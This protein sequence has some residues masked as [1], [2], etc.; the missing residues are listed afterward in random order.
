MIKLNPLSSDHGNLDRSHIF[1]GARLLLDGLVDYGPIPLTSSGRFNRTIVIWAAKNFDWPNETLE[2]LRILTK[3]PNEND[4]QPLSLLHKL[5]EELKL[6]VRVKNRFYIT[7][8]GC[9]LR[10]KHL[11]LFTLI[12]P[13][14]LLNVRNNTLERMKAETNIHWDWGRVIDIVDGTFDQEIARE[15]L[16]VALFGSQCATDRQRFHAKMET[17][18]GIMKPLFWAG[19]LVEYQNAGKFD[20]EEVFGKSELWPAL[21]S[22]RSDGLLQHAERSTHSK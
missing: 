5:L 22:L 14:F 13:Y 10:Q 7:D 2:K 21:V 15:K 17:S 16:C 1:R 9:T 12:V 6:G 3:A 19:L 20:L 8:L 11:D 4:F 18:F